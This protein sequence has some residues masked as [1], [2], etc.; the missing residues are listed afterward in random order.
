MKNL[1]LDVARFQFLRRAAAGVVIAAVPL[2]FAMPGSALHYNAVWNLTF[3]NFWGGV[4]LDAALAMSCFIS[5][6]NAVAC[7]AL[8]VA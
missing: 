7:A 8:A 5:P 6:L 2:L 1:S 3:N 4:V